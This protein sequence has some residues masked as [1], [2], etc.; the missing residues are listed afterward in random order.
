MRVATVRF[1]V[2]ASQFRF[3]CAACGER[4]E[5]DGEMRDLLL[6]EGCVFCGARVTD[7]EFTTA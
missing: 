4:F 3:V 7:A 6:D 5:T 2:T 1:A